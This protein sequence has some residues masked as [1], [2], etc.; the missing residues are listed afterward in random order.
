MK[1]PTY[2]PKEIEPALVNFWKHNQILEKLRTRN[3]KGKKFYFL[4]G[5]PYTSGRIHLGQAWNS[6]MKDMVLRYKRMNGFNVWDRAGYDMHGL[7]TEHK[8]MAKHNLQ[9]KQDIESFGIEKFSNECYAFSS[10]MAQKMNED[11]TRLGISLDFTDPYMPIKNEFIESE[12]LLIKKAHKKD[13]LYQGERALNWCAS[14]ATAC[15]KHE[16]EYQD[17]P[18]TSIYVKLQLESKE[19]EYIIIW[20]TTPW[21]MPLNLQVVVHPEFIYSKVKVGKEYWII[22]KE[23]LKNVMKLTD[24][25]Y[26]IVEEFQGTELS[27][28]KYIP[29]F[30]DQFEYIEKTKQEQTEM[31]TIILSKDEVHLDEGTGLVH[32]A[33]GCG[34]SN[35][36]LCIRHGVTPF[37]V[38]DEQGRYPGDHPLF[39]GLTAKKDDKKF[40]QL[41]DDQG[42]LIAK[43]SFTHSYPHCQRC[44]NPT[45]FRTTRQWFFKVEDLKEQMLEENK[46]IDWIPDAGKN[47]FTSWLEN[48]RDNSITKQRFWGTPVPIWECK[49]CDNKTVIG[50][51]EELK[52]KAGSIP[53][54]LHKP[55]IDDVKIKCEC[56]K[57][58]RRIP[59]V[60]DVWIDAGTTSWSCLYYPQKKEFFNEWF[61]ADFILEGKDQ[62]RGWFNLLMVASTLAFKKPSFKNVY[63]HGFITDVDGVKMSKSL[64]N[65]I[66]PYEVIDQYSADTLR[67]YTSQTNAGEDMNF[68]WDE[69]GLKHRYFNVLWN[70]HKFLITLTQEN[71]INP[72]KLD[73]KVMQDQFDIEERTMASKL[74]STIK[75]VTHLFETYQLDQISKQ[76]EDLYLDLSRTYIQLVRDK[77]STGKQ[78]DKELVIYMISTTLFNT[79]KLLAPIAPFITEAMYLNLKEEYTLKEDSIHEYTWPEADKSL[80]DETVEKDMAIA[81]EIIQVGLSAREKVKLSVRWPVKEVV[82]STASKDVE[83]SVTHLKDIIKTQLNAK[84]VNV[85]NG[86]EGVKETIKLDFAKIAPK[87]KELSPAI[88]A[89][90]ATHSKQSIMEQIEE[91]GAYTF[92]LEGRKI[93]LTK[94]DIIIERDIPA[95]YQAASFKMGTVFLNHERTPELEGEGFSREIMRRVQSLR[96]KEGLI[97]TDRIILYIKTSDDLKEMLAPHSEDIQQKV[98]AKKVKIDTL[99]PARKH[100]FVSTEKVKHEEFMVYFDKV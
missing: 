17:I 36:E 14:C 64:G 47:A 58:Q 34:D 11:L 6:G 20:T 21:T 69:I 25:D 70:V 50:S 12:W 46:N 54:N 49:D 51:I 83:N 74:H 16:L 22:A 76:I 43:T 86:L 63:M 37:N 29:P 26:D 30:P 9:T 39:G 67:Y 8:V 35:Y 48:L 89:Q 56:G 81:Q 3:K 96:K 79:L 15:A 33:P 5:P 92:T 68:S 82:V 95:P 93:E 94:E 40:A 42:S 7:P 19:N 31:F 84:D 85:K 62:I 66:S 59:D 32:L 24:K 72:F 28:K 61:P 73:D 78:E 60:L 55:W 100:Q 13:R 99:D 44:H 97:K 45:V 57:T 87:Y 65:I 90:F 1:Y 53:D 38:I 77:S 88:I 75:K 10:E 98:G 52:E 41:L 71:N 2:T 27:G 91:K 18:D 4:Q 80:I 23:L